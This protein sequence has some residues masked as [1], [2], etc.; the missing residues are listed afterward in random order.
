MKT[1]SVLFAEDIPH[2]GCAETQAANDAAALTM[3]IAK[4]RRSWQKTGVRASAR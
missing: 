3:L 4:C 1:Y 2:Y